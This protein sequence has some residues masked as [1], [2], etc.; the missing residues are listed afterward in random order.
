MSNPVNG[1]KLKYKRSK[2]QVYE[3]TKG[4]YFKSNHQNGP[5]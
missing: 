4:F 1:K 5:L 2:W 3:S